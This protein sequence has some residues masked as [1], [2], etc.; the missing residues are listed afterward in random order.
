[1]DEARAGVSGELPER[2]SLIW[3]RTAGRRGT[4]VVHTPK[5]IVRNPR[6]SMRIASLF[7]GIGGFELG[8]SRSG[9]TTSITCESDPAAIAVLQSQFPGVPNHDDVRTLKSVPKDV[10]LLCAGFP[11]QDLSQAGK[12]AGIS[13]S[14]SGLIHEV[15]RLL[16]KRRVRWLVIE[17][18]SF[19]LHLEGGRA[20]AHIVDGLESLGYR[21]AYRVVNSLAFVPQRRERVF[22]VAST[23]ADPADVLFVDEAL[24]PEQDTQIGRLAHGFYWTEGI[25]GLGWAIDAIPTLKNGSTVGIPSS[26]ALLL[27]DGTIIKPDLRDAERLQGFPEDWTQAASKAKR[28]TFR[29]SL[30]GNAVT[31]PVA[32]WLGQRL[33]APGQY[34]RGRDVDLGR[35]RRWPRAAR[36][37]G[38]KRLS[39]RISSIPAWHERQHLHEFLNYP[40]SL[41]S[42][43]ATLGF[44]KRTHRGTLRFPPGFLSAVETHLE[45]MVERES[46]QKTIFGNAADVAVIAA[47]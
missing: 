4:N 27:P 44:Y 11:C 39:V 19:M 23:E 45:K 14:R 24:A 12:T 6:N 40:G 3:E 36:F 17:N 33:A 30:V 16:E 28:A 5:Q 34:D 29:W 46:S 43:R 20:L 41:L 31:V 26:P 18:V 35:E 21:W 25:R 7:A 10:E 2:N 37:D 42:A 38:R 32:A 47:E 22:L 1:M 13:G 15:F 9:H 8:L